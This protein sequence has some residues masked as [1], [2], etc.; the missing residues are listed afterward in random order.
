MLRGLPR[1]K[2][3]DWWSTQSGRSSSCSSTSGTS[4]T[5]VFMAR[6]RSAPLALLLVFPPAILYAAIV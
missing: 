5:W 6:T 2:K 1:L 4:C 3:L